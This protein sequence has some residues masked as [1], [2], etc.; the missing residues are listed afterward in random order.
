MRDGRDA[1]VEQPRLVAEAAGQRIGGDDAEAGLVGDE[2]RGM[3]SAGEGADEQ[4]GMSGD[5]GVGEKQVGQP[6]GEAVDEGGRGFGRESGR[7]LD[8]HL[9]RA[10]VGGTPG[11]VLVDP[12]THLVVEG[13][14]GGEVDRVWM[15]QEEALGIGALAGAG[16]AED[17][18]DAV[19]VGRQAQKLAAAVTKSERPAWV[20][21]S[22]VPLA[23]V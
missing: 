10:P 22:G 15:R 23:A 1:L 7:Q 4:V 17:Q 21:N 18:G 8:R 3:G 19:V 20:Q 13:L 2:D 14:P 9:D 11:A 5:I 12:A 6:Q 16:A